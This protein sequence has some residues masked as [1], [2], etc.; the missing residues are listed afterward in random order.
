[1]R[2]F[3]YIEHLDAVSSDCD[4]KVGHMINAYVYEVVNYCPV[5]VGN[6]EL[7]DIHPLE[8]CTILVKDFLFHEK[9]I[10]KREKINLVCVKKDRLI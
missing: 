10:A 1:M 8:D 6:C 2:S 4:S 7:A 5:F 9:I 3:F